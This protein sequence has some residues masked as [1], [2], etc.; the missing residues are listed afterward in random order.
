MGTIRNQA[1]RSTVITF[2][3]IGIGM[4]S[5]GTM[6]FTLSTEE[7]GALFLLGIVSSFV[8]TIFSLG[9]PQITLK[10]FPH[11]RNAKE[12]HNGFFLFSSTVSS[13]GSLLGLAFFYIFK[14]L[15]VGDGPGTELIQ[16]YTYLIPPLIF[17]GIFFRNMDTYL[18]ML[19]KSVIGIFIEGFVLKIT[20]L[21]GVILFWMQLI[22]FEKLAYIYTIALALPGI[23]T[24]A[25]AYTQT[26]KR[27]L[28][29]S[30]F[31]S[32]ELKN[33]IYQNG[34][35]GILASASGIII[36]TVDSIMINNLIGTD[37]VGIYSTLFFAGI[38]VST[39]AR[40][41]KRI[42][43]AVIAE[44]WKTNQLS[45]IASI[46]SKSTKT[47]LISG[48][49]LFIVGWACIQPA[50]TFLPEYKIGLYVFFFIGLAQLIDMMTG[51]NMEIIASSKYFKYNTYFNIVLAIVSVIANLIFI[52]NWGIVG[53]A[54]AS[55][56]SLLTINII[57]WYFLKKSFNLQPFDRS[58][59]IALIVGISF[60]ILVSIIKIPLD[61][62]PLIIFYFVTI[63]ALYWTIIYQLN[64]SEDISKVILKIL[65]KTKFKS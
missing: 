22:N 46:Y 56:M 62:I 35:F 9:F 57:K 37:S 32:R 33:Q 49:F 50:L 13:I 7:I 48:Q 51:V 53:A 6:P 12:N 15:L 29:N 54:F 24:L 63:S 11:F 25:V 45:N 3:G 27:T 28:P 39:P 60:F 31:F 61:P 14:D 64:L 40:G 52:S 8:A 47:L 65:K 17:C 5:R 30:A 23:V 1:M 59:L 55:T 18:R 36:L 26:E 58:F 10:L 43:S 44:S 21:T 42:A 38:L 4:L 2:F 34:F 16:E 41:V 19:Y 20:I